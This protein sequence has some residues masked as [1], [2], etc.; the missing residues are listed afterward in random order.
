MQP[1][2]VSRKSCRF[3]S[4]QPYL[5]FWLHSLR[6]GLAEGWATTKNT[7][8]TKERIAEARKSNSIDA[9]IVFREIGNGMDLWLHS[10]PHC[11]PLI[12]VFFVFF[13]VVLPRPSVKAGFRFK[14]RKPPDRDDRRL[15]IRIL[16]RELSEIY[17]PKL[18]IPS[19]ADESKPQSPKTW[20][21]ELAS[22][23]LLADRAGR[24]SGVAS[25]AT[26][27]WARCS[28]AVGATRTGPAINEGFRSCS[29]AALD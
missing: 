16:L 1:V 28:L 5:E 6:G 3:N 11:T 17:S 24:E 9:P 14:T 15:R 2:L 20:S 23:S 18:A 21:T 19:N 27:D 10:M 25:G 12:F 13:V 8:Y 26:D 22:P 4:C 29:S 7:K